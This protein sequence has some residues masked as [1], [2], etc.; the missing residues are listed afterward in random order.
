MVD[1]PVLYKTP[2]STDV[3]WGQIAPEQEQTIPRVGTEEEMPLRCNHKSA[4]GNE[5]QRHRSI[6]KKSRFIIRLVGGSVVIN[7]Y[8]T[9][10]TRNSGHFVVTK[11]SRTVYQ[12]ER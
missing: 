12:F 6:I 4:K 7:P 8:G 5:D 11:D 10:R 3:N 2:Y 1:S 9:M